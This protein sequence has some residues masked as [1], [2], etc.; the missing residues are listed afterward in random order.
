MEDGQQRIEARAVPSP[1]TRRATLSMLSP[2]DLPH[3][4]VRTVVV[5]A[6]PATVFSFFVESERFAT[7]WGVGSHLEAREGGEVRIELPGPTRIGGRVES[8]GPGLRLVFTYGY[9]DPAKP[10]PVGGSRVRIAIEP[11]THGAS[12]QFRHE[13][14]SVAVRESHA[15]GW[16][17]H[18]SVL[19]NA[20]SRAAFERDLGGRVDAWFEA[21]NTTDSV[22]RS[23]LL[24]RC[25]T[26]DIELR[27]GWSALSGV[28][29]VAA[30]IGGAQAV[31]P[32]LALVR[33]GSARHCQG[34][35]LADWSMR[36][37]ETVVQRG[38]HVF[39]LAEDG[40]FAAVTGVAMSG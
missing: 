11:H 6:S 29:E 23:A 32:G 30:Q 18:L 35:A 8:V 10:I 22:A 40:R 5:R 21:W 2:M 7:W 31:M 3:A 14:A 34:T 9:E 12:L 15:Q 20:A 24:A 36:R 28:D 25:C 17:Y 26:D 39:A 33:E 1:W 13:V 4:V 38:T 16:R 19:A 27:D 37:G